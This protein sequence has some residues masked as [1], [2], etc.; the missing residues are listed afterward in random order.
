[1]SRKNQS[2]SQPEGEQPV[3]VQDQAPVEAQQPQPEA[4]AATSEAPATATNTSAPAAPETPANTVPPL[5]QQDVVA[6]L[7]VAD[8]GRAALAVGMAPE[9]FA[10][11]LAK[12]KV[13]HKEDLRR[14]SW[15][16]P[17]L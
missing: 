6:V 13:I 16:V 3:Q 2:I 9:A 14:L 4:Q 1:M 10:Q 5:R 8:L 15:A 11:A 17:A 7:K 12:A